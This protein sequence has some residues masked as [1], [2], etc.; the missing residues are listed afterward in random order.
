MKQKYFK[1]HFAFDNLD[2]VYETDGENEKETL[3]RVRR[4]LRGRGLV[5]K[6]MDKIAHSAV[7]G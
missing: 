5:D 6:G 3:V 2:L 1:F 4:D 7:G